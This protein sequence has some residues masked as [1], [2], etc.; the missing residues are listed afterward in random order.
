M[1]I[2]SAMNEG[3]A[4]MQQSQKKMLQTAHEIARAG[5]PTDASTLNPGGATGSAPRSNAG[6]AVDDLNATNTVEAGAAS[7]KTAGPYRSDTVDVTEALLEQRQQQLVFDASANVVT[8][9]N[10]TLGRLIDDLS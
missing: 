6:T 8:A 7:A 5:V 2:N 9:A 10:E 4:G 1:L 3:L